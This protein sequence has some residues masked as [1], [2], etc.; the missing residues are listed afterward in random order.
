MYSE[1]Q[2]ED[3]IR[4]SVATTAKAV[5]Q[6]VEKETKI[7]DK[8]TQEEIPNC[9]LNTIKDAEGNS[10]ALMVDYVYVELEKEG[11]KFTN[12]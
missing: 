1:K 8:T 11:I 7:V 9:E 2:V 5:M 3:L 6:W 10:K 12:I 4:K